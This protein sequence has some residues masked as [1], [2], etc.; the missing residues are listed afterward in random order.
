M[1]RSNIYTFAS[2]V[3]LTTFFL[4]GCGSSPTNEIT[5]DQTT[6]S[7][8]SVESNTPSEEE[9]KAE[10]ERLAEE[11][12][13]AEEQRLAEEQKK[14]EE[15]R[16]AEEKRIA[17]EPRNAFLTKNSITITKQGEF[18]FPAVSATGEDIMV[19]SY[20]EVFE[21]T[22]GCEIGTK[23]I[24]CHFVNEAQP[25]DYNL[26]IDMFDRYTGIVFDLYYE[27][28]IKL[29]ETEV[30]PTGSISLAIDDNKYD[31]GLGSMGDYDDEGRLSIVFLIN[32]PI[33]YDGPVFV[34]GYPPQNAEYS[35]SVD[36]IYL[37]DESPEY[38]E[39]TEYYCFT[40][41]DD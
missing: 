30:T 40:V 39:N 19:K 38:K 2:C 24:S 25:D 17:E 29:N 21:S 28:G 33:S 18:T 27:P 22:E 1:R 35:E 4:F 6:N 16:L 36:H 11:Q 37:F 41:S 10:E 31:I 34:I 23:N 14:A 20:V 32:C 3:L 5:A 12:K 7:T 26:F 9:K 13:K 15:E 8:T